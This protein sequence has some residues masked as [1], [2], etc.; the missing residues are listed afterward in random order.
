MSVSNVYN[1]LRICQQI[2]VLMTPTPFIIGVHSLHARESMG[3][4]LDV[5]Y[6][7]LDGGAI[8]LPDNLKIHTINEN[9]LAKTQHELSLVFK[10]GSNSS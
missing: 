3:E 8:H 9:L 5:I 2:E 6:V 1:F 4:L 10:P 7:D